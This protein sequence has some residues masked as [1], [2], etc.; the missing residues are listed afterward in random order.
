MKKNLREFK[1]RC[2]PTPSP[3]KWIFNW[4]SR[5]CAKNKD[6]NAGL[7]LSPALMFHPH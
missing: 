7:N 2:K 1:P 3:S 5:S 4:I 6:L